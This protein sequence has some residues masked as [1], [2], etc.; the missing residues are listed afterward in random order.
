M[1]VM[2]G[3]SITEAEDI[4]LLILRNVEIL[5]SITQLDDLSVK[6]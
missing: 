5:I 6:P 3:T 2:E 4:V 1:L